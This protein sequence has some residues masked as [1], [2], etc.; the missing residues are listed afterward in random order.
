LL[1]FL[2]LALR[3]SIFFF[4]F[5]YSVVYVCTPALPLPKT[6]L[7][8][9]RRPSTQNSAEI[10]FNFISV[11]LMMKAVFIKAETHKKHLPEMTGYQF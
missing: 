10:I 2:L 8:L 11:P 1:F 7:L 3:N 9:N 5:I 4:N 6:R